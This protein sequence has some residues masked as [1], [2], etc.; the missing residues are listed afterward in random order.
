MASSSMILTTPTTSC[1]VSVTFLPDKD[2][3]LFVQM[4][5]ANLEL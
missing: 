1:V 4:V 5:Q 3:P 2:K